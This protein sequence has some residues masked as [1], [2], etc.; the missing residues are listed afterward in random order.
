MT[1]KSFLENY[2]HYGSNIVAGKKL[3]AHICAFLRKTDLKLRRE[4]C[5]NF[6]LFGGDQDVSSRLT[7]LC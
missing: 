7:T 4:S 3:L 1:P 5:V 6:Q 2:T